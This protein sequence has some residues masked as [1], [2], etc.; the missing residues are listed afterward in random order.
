MDGSSRNRKALWIIGAALACAGV[1]LSIGIAYPTPVPNTAL[2]AEWECHRSA[3]I[4]TTCRKVSHAQP[5]IHRSPSS[6]LMEMR[7]A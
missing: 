7:R 4:M 2:G 3:A 6:D 1:A 5:T